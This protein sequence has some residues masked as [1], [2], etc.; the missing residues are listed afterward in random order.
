MITPAVVRDLLET[1]QGI[2]MRCETGT[3]E[4]TAYRENIMHVAWYP[5]AP[6]RLPMWGI[7]ADAQAEVPTSCVQDDGSIYLK[8]EALSARV[9]RGDASVEFLDRSGKRLTKLESYSLTPE[10]ILGEDTWRLLAAFSAQ[11]NEHYY[12]LGQHQDGRLDLGGQEYVLWHD[13]S[14]KGGEVVAIPFLVTDRGYA[15][16]FEN[17]SRMKIRPG[18]D[19][20]TQWE[21]EVADALSFFLICGETTDALYS[22]YR[23]LCGVTPMPPIAGLGFIQ[24]KQRYT[25][26]QE[27]LD[28]ARTYHEKGYPCDIFVV[29]WYHWKTLGDMSF[30]ERYWPDVQAMNDTLHRMGYAS[31]ISCW[32]RFMK[33]SAYYDEL[34]AHHWFMHDAAGNTV[35]GSETDRRGA[36]IDTTGPECGAWYMETIAR[37]YGSKGFSYWW[38]DENEPDISPHESYLHAGTGARVHNLYPLTHSKCIWEG[39]RARYPHRCLILSR[40]AFPGAQKYGTTF[41][42]S[43][44][45]PEWEVLKRQIPTALNFCASGMAYWSSDIGGW[46][47]LPD[48]KD[49]GEENPLLLKTS[50]D[51]TRVTQGQYAE[52][53]VRWFQ[54]GAF[55][56][57]FRTHGSRREN[58]VWSYGPEAEKI[59]VK[60]LRLRYRLMPY[61]YS[62]A[63]RTTQTGAPF[64]RALWMDF[65]DEECTRCADEFLF[66]PALL[67]APVTEPAQRSREVY[68]PRGAE[69]IDYWTGARWK[70]GRSICTDAP[71]DRIPIFVR[72]GSILPMGEDV[73]STQTPQNQIV[74]RVYPGADTAFTLYTDDGCTYD[75]E[76]GAFCTLHLKWN[77]REGRLFAD[78]MLLPLQWNGKTLQMELAAGEA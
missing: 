66:G 38:T 63:Y 73:P 33:E 29:D 25:S 8:T 19:G 9:C 27:L 56:P 2:S 55:C 36:L 64:M 76:K 47:Y 6:S 11:E 41:W 77:D 43:D 44:I 7:E 30:D 32:P 68:L 20:V 16:L 58:E 5:A 28:A 62:L 10:H 4:L 49:A 39:H 18:V 70:G 14:H 74:L 21:A 69:W 3:L 17:T 72:A 50:S 75:Y 13:Y 31:M 15:V 59:L 46:Q 22:G 42:S 57:T 53:Y 52:L 67:I 35:Y 54:F 37:N 1:K 61:I 51:G 24:S 60:F 71:I 34:E 40:A 26:Q 65:P 23:T 12:G 48:T 78:G 45:Y